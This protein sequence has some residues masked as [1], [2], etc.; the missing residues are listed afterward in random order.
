MRQAFHS[1]VPEHLASRQMLHSHHKPR[2]APLYIRRPRGLER[3]PR[4]GETLYLREKLF[5]LIPTKRD[6]CRSNVSQPFAVR[7]SIVFDFV[8]PVVPSRA[9][10][11]G[12]PPNP[13]H[14]TTVA[15]QS[16][17]RIKGCRLE[18]RPNIGVSRAN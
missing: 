7:W 15:A 14:S 6:E 12:S 17:G 10:A 16:R 5:P 8:N 11:I 13:P 4:G 9:I 18:L 1:R 3:G 2:L